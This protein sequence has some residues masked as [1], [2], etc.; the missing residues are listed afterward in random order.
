MKQ[1]PHPKST[2]RAPSFQRSQRT[3]VAG[4]R[5]DG[6]DA[7]TFAHE[8]RRSGG[9]AAA[10]IDRRLPVEFGELGVGAV[11][12]AADEDAGVVDKNIKPEALGLDLGR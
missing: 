11:D 5:A 12:G 10:H 2:E 4:T 3:E 8:F 7:A 6:D 1:K 9:R